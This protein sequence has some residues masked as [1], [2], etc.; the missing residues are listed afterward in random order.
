MK[1]I[2]VSFDFILR[3]KGAEKKVPDVV[4]RLATK[5]ILGALKKELIQLSSIQLDGD[6][7][8]RITTV[9]QEATGD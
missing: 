3:F 7:S 9:A 2:N 1:S 8:V 5:Q 4:M 6:R